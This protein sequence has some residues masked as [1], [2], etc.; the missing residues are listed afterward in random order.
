MRHI[1]TL[2]RRFYNIKN[3]EEKK[4]GFYFWLKPEI[5]EMINSHIEDADK[6]SRSAFVEEAIKYYSAVIDGDKNK[7]V[8]IDKLSLL[9]KS[10]LKNTENRMANILFKIAGEI[11]ILNY[12]IGPTMI[13][14]TESEMQNLRN[15]AYD[16]V[17]KSHGF[18]SIENVINEEL[19]AINGE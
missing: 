2:K 18:I 4:C 8:L 3:K 9:Y 6:H 19:N 12:L 16:K 1:L 15:Y 17:R 7:D 11:S 13:N 10:T 14:M 5:N